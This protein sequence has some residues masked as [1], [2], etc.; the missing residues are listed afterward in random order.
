MMAGP[1]CVAAAGASGDE[2][3]TTT[4]GRSAV[5]WVGCGACGRFIVASKYLGMV[6]NGNWSEK[7]PGC[8]FKSGIWI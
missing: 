1:L 3:V 2:P 8:N 4:A 7:I 6:V 5:A